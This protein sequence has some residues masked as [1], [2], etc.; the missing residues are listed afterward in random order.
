MANNK[1]SK[2]R[3]EIAERNRQ[4]NRTYKSALRTLMKRCFTAC[5]SYAQEPG[6][7]AKD[8][9]QTSMN[10]AFSKIDKAVKCGVLHRNTGAHQKSRISAAVKKAIEPA[11]AVG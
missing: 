8:V 4:R 3:I 7:Q 11:A 9:V 10:A 6:D 1:S 5:S 2:K